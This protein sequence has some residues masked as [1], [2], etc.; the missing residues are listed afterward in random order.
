MEIDSK[1][2]NSLVWADDIVLLSETDK[3]LKVLLKILE[4]FCDENKLTINSDKTKC[5]IFNKTGRLLRQQFY[6]KETQLENVCT[7]K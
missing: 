7:Y 3:G 1:S 5:M 2:I 6:F 4:D